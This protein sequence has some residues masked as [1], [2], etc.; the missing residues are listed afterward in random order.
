M[1]SA[2]VVVVLLVV[3]L[4][5]VSVVYVSS[6]QGE[7]GQ[8]S[9]QSQQIATLESQIQK[10]SAAVSSGK[11]SGGNVSLP[12]MN[13]APT[14]RAIRETWYLSSSAHQ[15]RF[16]PSF[17]VVNQGDTVKL[18][19]IDNDTVAHDFVIGPA[20]NIIVNATVPGLVNDL[21]GHNF[22]TPAANN[23]PG[24]VVKG[25][26]GNVSASYS[27][28][29]R[30]AGIYEFVC[31]YHVEVG[32]IGYLVVLPNLAYTSVASNSTT[33]T[34]QT[35]GASVPVGILA[36]AGTPGTNQGFSPDRITVVIGV[37]NTVVWTNNDS[38]P[39]T[40]TANGESFDSGFMAPGAT[41]TYTFTTPGVYG[42]HCTYHPWMTGTVVVKK[43]S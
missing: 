7:A 28:V 19:F 42:Y 23:S 32:M 40:V 34:V 43:A 35:S 8:L 13:Q 30:Y 1:S 15:D 3:A 39:H 24:V 20:Y 14:T 31:T 37:N 29:A 21:T 18:T 2:G 33:T 41:F 26:P 17:I 25:T 6:T 4:A 36:G 27:F 9:S 10:L 11:G 12:V 22:T 16:D 38:Q 5:A